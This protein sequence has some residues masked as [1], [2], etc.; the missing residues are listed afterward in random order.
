MNTQLELRHLR[1]FVAVAGERH[2]S[3]AAA[4]LGVT[5]PVVSRQI[6]SLEKIL[7]ISLFS[8]TR[9]TVVL[10]AEGKS[11]FEECQNILRHIDQ[12]RLQSTSP[13]TSFPSHM[14]LVPRFM[15][16]RKS[17]KN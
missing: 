17:Q 8:S 2:F 6:R 10:T 12:V 4:A 13:K 9:P 15:V 11:F 7:G 14:N 3:R 1:Y 5:Q 16:L